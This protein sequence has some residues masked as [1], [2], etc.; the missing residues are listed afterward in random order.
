MKKILAVVV[1][2]VAAGVAYFV[3]ARAL[4]ERDLRARFDAYLSARNTNEF[5][6][7]QPYYL[8]LDDRQRVSLETAMKL[9]KTFGV[10]TE[11]WEVTS[12]AIDGDRA[13]VTY[14]SIGRAG[15]TVQLGVETS[16]TGKT[17][18]WQRFDGEWYLKP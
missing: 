5:E 8:T 16:E 10:V 3:V 13:V 14:N 9:R 15:S 11:S 17:S 18:E 12:V 7:V 1:G 2:L 4:P 6:K